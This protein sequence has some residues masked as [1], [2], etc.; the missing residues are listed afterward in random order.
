MRTATPFIMLFNLLSLVHHVSLTIFLLSS[1][2]PVAFSQQVPEGE[3]L[4]V[5]AIPAFRS[6]RPCVQSC[7][8]QGANLGIF[9]VPSPEVALQCSANSCYCR[10]DL[11]TTALSVISACV[12]RACGTNEVDVSSGVA[13]FTNYCGSYVA[14]AAPYPESNTESTAA[15]GA[16]RQP[17]ET[18]T[19]TTA[20][21]PTSGA[22]VS[23]TAREWA[24]G[25]WLGALVAV[26][27]PAWM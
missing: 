24:Q 9:Y 14:T 2:L 16:S 19:V 6:G 1:T 26:L 13:I 21:K 23:T 20:A 12:T 18:V 15:P 25:P 3:V 11:R 4:T 22:S 7:L 8:W 27:L 10:P 5:S 17:R